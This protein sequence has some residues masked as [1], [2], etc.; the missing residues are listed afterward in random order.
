MTLSLPAGVGL[1]GAGDFGEFCAGAYEGLDEVR[2]VAVA[3][4][5]H[6]R[7]RA[8]APRGAAVYADY[9]ELLADPAVDV[10]AVNTPPHLHAQLAREAAEAGKHVFVEKPLATSLEDA[11]AVIAAAERAG[12]QVSVDFVLRHHP[13]HRLAAAVIHSRALGPFRHWALENLATDEGLGPDHWF[14]DPE[15][16][17]GIHVEH[18]VHFFDLCNFLVGQ[19]PTVVCG[20]KQKRPDG[21]VDRVS[22]LVQYGD[23]VTATFYHAFNQI[24]RFERTTLR[25][26]CE[27]GEMV[28]DGWIPTEL[29]LCGWVDESGLATLRTLFDGRVHVVER[30]E[31]EASLFEH[32][33]RTETLTAVVEAEFSVPDRQGAYRR[34]IQAGM[35]DLVRAVHEGRAPAVTAEDGLRS[36][37]VAL[38]A[39]P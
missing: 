26:N 38:A 24:R 37:E 4:V 11:R 10:V 13:L 9:R 27:R 2:L 17:G 12:V 30:L 29:W 33:G 20:G 3:D 18:G 34:A 31:G 8:V 23:E 22:A 15:R 19:V 5:D 6:A 39:S 7:A 35:R 36:L 1:I 28:I 25:L 21:R 32:G 14:W 16:S